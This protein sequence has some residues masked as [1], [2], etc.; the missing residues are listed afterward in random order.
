MTGQKHLPRR[1]GWP[2]AWIILLLC[3]A[4]IA[5]NGCGRRTTP[6][7]VATEAGILLQGIGADPADLD[8]QITTG[9][10]EGRI[11]SALFEGLVIPDPETLEPQPGVAR[12]WRISAD[13]KRF[14]F[15]LRPEARWSDGMPLTA[16]DFVFAYR[17]ILHPALGAEYAKLLFP[18]RGARGFNSG[19][20][21]DPASIAVYA[22]DPHTLGIE[23]DNPTPHFLQMLFHSAYYPVPAHVIRKF[24]AVYTRGTHWTR[25]GNLVGNGAFVLTAWNIHEQVSVRA[26]PNYWDA[27]SVRLNG[28]DFIPIGNA[29]TEERA[30]RSGQLHLTDSLPLAKRDYYRRN[31]SPYLQLEPWLGVYYYLVNT[32]RPPFDDVRVRQAF[33]LSLDRE[34]LV[35]TI[36]R[37][38]E[39]PAHHFTPPGLGDYQPPQIISRDDELARQLLAEAGYPGGEGFPTVEL[40]YN[41]S[42]F[43]RPIAEALQQ[44]W[45]QNLGVRVQLVNQSWSV[46]LATRRARDY[47]LARAG[48]IGDYLDVSTFID[49]WTADSGLNHSGWEN[50]GFDDLVA[51]AAAEPDPARRLQLYREAESILLNEAPV[52]PLYFYNR[53]FLKRPEVRGISGNVLDTHVYK[54]VWLD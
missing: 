28:I 47:T 11:L 41:T 17:R 23:L 31:D 40:L 3:V 14:T 10:T 20:H 21:D 32:T 34:A 50:A 6:V 48:W 46:Y 52:I 42:E 37:G 44:M 9:L 16:H 38:G 54:H 19:T 2:H 12:D 18:I 30:F 8:P 26:N 22:E 25:P 13:R 29:N 33:N 36:T 45:R 15:Y 43:H 35:E 27:A 7:E 51:A 24:D 5:G 49:M 1:R 4:L 39:A 53:I